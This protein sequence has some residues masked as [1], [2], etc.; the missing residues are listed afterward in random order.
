MTKSKELTLENLKSL[1]ALMKQ[2]NMPPKKVIT[3]AQARQ[4]NSYD[5]VLNLPKLNWEVGDQY[6][7]LIT[8]DRSIPIATTP[9]G[10]L[11]HISN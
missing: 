11:A 7:I 8:R 6:Y 5:Q 4:F 2:N 9:D 10:C 1:V 3:K